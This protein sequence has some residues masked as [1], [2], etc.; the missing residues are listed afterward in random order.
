MLSVIMLS[1]IMLNVVMLSVVTLSVV[2][3]NVVM[4]SVVILNVVA[5]HIRALVGQ[6]QALFEILE[7]DISFLKTNASAYCPERKRFL[8]H[9][10][11]ISYAYI[12]WPLLSFDIYT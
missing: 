12:L 5:P 11:L 2:M 8:S 9:A 10:R 4:L 1:V 3:L 6:V 7:Q